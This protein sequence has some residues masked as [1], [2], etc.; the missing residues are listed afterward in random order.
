ME[1]VGQ[2]R[3]RVARV[4]DR[5]DE[6]VGHLRAGVSLRA[7]I[8]HVVLGETPIGD[9]L[10]TAIALPVA[11]YRWPAGPQYRLPSGWEHTTPQFPDAEKERCMVEQT[12]DSIK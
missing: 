11:L 2:E 10:M 6:V 5:V 12:E 3:G 8:Q 4:A 9:R 1:E 7:M